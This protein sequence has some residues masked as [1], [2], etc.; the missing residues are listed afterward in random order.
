LP[1]DAGQLADWDRALN[2]IE[3]DLFGAVRLVRSWDWIG[4][5]GQELMEIHADKIEA[6]QE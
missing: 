5:N 3:R 6:S 1:E 2:T 4:A